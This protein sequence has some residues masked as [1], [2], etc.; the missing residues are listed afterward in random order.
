V[1]ALFLLA[2]SLAA[3]AFFRHG[4]G[5]L[6]LLACAAFSAL[7]ALAVGINSDLAI[8]LDTFVADWFDARR[9]PRHDAEAMGVFKY[10]GRPFHVLAAA[11]VCGLPLSLRRRSALPVALIFG[12]VAVG[13]LVEQTL[14]ATIGRTASSGLL[15]Q[16]PHSF[17]S[18][19]VTGAA[20]LLGSIA[21]C[22]AAGR[23]SGVRTAAA[24]LVVGGVLWVAGLA[25][26]T[27]AHTCTDVIGG[28]LLGGAIVAACGAVYG[29]ANPRYPVSEPAVRP[30]ETTA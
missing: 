8:A 4:R 24:V 12:A 18:G 1:I 20:A 17:P 30:A 13:V 9:T 19:H 15:A 28:M 21:V 14:K 5:R 25:L 27:G 2:V 16:Y 26:Y 29:A 11:V 22:L 23:S 3:A 6:V 10:L 7:A